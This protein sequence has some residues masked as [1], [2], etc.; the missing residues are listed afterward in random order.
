MSMKQYETLLK[1]IQNHDDIQKVKAWR[2]YLAAQ[3]V[4]YLP[5]A[6]F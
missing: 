1:F 2:E 6:E 3:Y 5:Q 4:D